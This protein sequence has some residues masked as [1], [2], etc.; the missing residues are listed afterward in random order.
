VVDAIVI[1]VAAPASAVA[2]A[3]MAAES[4]LKSDWPGFGSVLA[5]V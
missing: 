2:Y 5:L 3:V 4:H 1:V